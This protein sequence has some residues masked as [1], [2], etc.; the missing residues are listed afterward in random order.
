MNDYAEHLAQSI[1]NDA[2]IN[3]QDLN[4][5]KSP[6]YQKAKYEWVFSDIYVAMPLEEYIE[7]F[8]LTKEQVSATYESIYDMG[9][10]EELTPDDCDYTELAY[11]IIQ[12]M[13]LDVGKHGRDI[14][15]KIEAISTG[16]TR[17]GGLIKQLKYHLNFEIRRFDE[18][19]PKFQQEIFK[20]LFFFYRLKNQECSEIE[21]L[22]LLSKHS[23]EN[24]DNTIL[25]RKTR[26][27]EVIQHVTNSL[28]K[29]VSLDVKESMKKGLLQIV[30]DWES[31]F[32]HIPMA[33]KV[34]KS[35]GNIINL[36]AAFDAI[37]DFLEG[38]IER[39]IFEY[40]QSPIETLYFFMIKSEFLGYVNDMLFTNRTQ[41]ENNYTVPIELAEKFQHISQK[42]MALDDIRGYLQ[43]NSVE[44]AKSVYHNKPTKSD[45]YR[46]IRKE[47]TLSKVLKIMGFLKRYKGTLFDESGNFSELLIISCLQAIF[48]DDASEKLNYK[49]HG[50]QNHKKHIRVQVAL[51]SDEHPFE[52]VQV[53]WVRKVIDRFNAN[54][55]KHDERLF[56]IELEKICD[57]WMSIILD[58]P[59]IEDMLNTHNRYIRKAYEA[60]GLDGDRL[61]D[62]RNFEL[63]LHS[64]GYK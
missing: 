5:K 30:T 26:N 31:F 11:N 34:S 49:F 60:F 42:R 22:E 53:Y 59:N 23:M 1:I 37:A 6:N 63:L 33:I 45:D 17:P 10:T 25:G 14:E 4:Y 39:D 54:L 7:R 44:V 47:E 41:T 48:Q 27:A 9:N 43:N 40:Q 46:N 38:E 12:T 2:G 19:N 35:N 24:A 56:M 20:I 28:S 3:I 58:I 55:G 32:I 62:V 57:M 13:N 8:L 18:N 16:F 51:K 15:D 21:V 61:L 36:Q 64:Q 29:E 52:A 50:F